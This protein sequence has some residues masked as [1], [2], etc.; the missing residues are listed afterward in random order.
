MKSFLDA[1]MIKRELGWFSQEAFNTGLRKTVN[2]CLE[3]ISNQYVRH[4]DILIALAVSP[5]TEI[6]DS[7]EALLMAVQHYKLSDLFPSSN[8]IATYTL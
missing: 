2:G 1:R 7:Q 4:K 3:R 5:S 6:M 8:F